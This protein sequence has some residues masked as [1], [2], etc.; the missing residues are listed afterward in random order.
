[1]YRITCDGITLY[2]PDNPVLQL[3]S[4]TLKTGQ[5][6]AGTLTFVLAPTHPYLSRIKARSSIISVYRDGALYFRGSPLNVT[7][8]DT[9]LVTVTAEGALAWLGDSVQP[10][11]EYHNMTVR[12][13]L[14]TYQQSDCP[15]YKI[16]RRTAL[17][18]LTELL[19][20]SLHIRKSIV[21]S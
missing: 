18:F 13:Y 12:T 7:E 6:I 2:E 5:N 9:G 3:I 19:P 4:G 21:F 20:G 8:S 15:G 10:F 14:E 1:M 11:A 17:R 16:C